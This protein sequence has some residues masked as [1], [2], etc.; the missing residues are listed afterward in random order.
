MIWLCLRQ[1]A[2]PVLAERRLNLDVVA[3]LGLCI[4][5]TPTQVLWMPSALAAADE[6]R[7]GIEADWIV[8]GTRYHPAILGASNMLSPI[9]APLTFDILTCLPNC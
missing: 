9:A 8:L 5:T 3:E 7:E 1:E 4:P 6:S 2:M